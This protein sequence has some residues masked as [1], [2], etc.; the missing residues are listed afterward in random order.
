MLVMDED[1]KVLW[2]EALLSGEYTQGTDYLRNMQGDYCCL[3]VLC[4]VFHKATGRGRWAVSTG[5]RLDA[6]WEFIVDDES[7]VSTLAVAVIDWA[8]IAPSPLLS[9]QKPNEW[10]TL[11]EEVTVTNGLGVPRQ[12]HELTGV[13]DYGV[14]FA[15]IAELL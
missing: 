14:P 11:T 3:G 7:A 10:G 13:N 4:D 2:K 5:A 12:Y 6:V 9:P 1:K 8:G 15:K